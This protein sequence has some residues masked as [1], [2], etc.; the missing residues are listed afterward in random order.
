[1]WVVRLLGIG[2]LVVAGVVGLNLVS[3]AV[4]PC[5][6]DS[7]TIPPPGQL[8]VLL[9]VFLDEC[10]SVAGEVVS[11]DIGELVVEMDRGEYV[12]RVR[13]RGPAEVFEQVPLG[14]RVQ[15]A[16]RVGE[17]EDEGYV[18][19]YGVDRGWWGNLREN[20]PGD[21]AHALEPHNRPNPSPP[22]DALEG[23]P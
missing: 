2:A 17:H 12:Q 16:G 19:R 21:V 11:R 6:A 3:P 20:L 15:V 8:L 13:V 22:D 4:D 10:V 7:P 18:I 9:D 1:M 5:P 14:G 23:A